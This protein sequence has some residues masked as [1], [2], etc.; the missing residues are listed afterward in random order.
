MRRKLRIAIL[1]T[2]G[3]PNNFGGFEQCAEKIGVRAAS[4]GHEITV[5]NPSDHLYSS[6]KWNG[7]TLKKIF[8]N[9]RRL[10][11]LG[12]FLFDYLSLKDAIKRDFDIILELGYSPS[13]LF[14]YLKK[15]TRAKI[16]TNMAGMEWQRSK[17]N[18]VA[19][20][21]IQFSERIAIRLSDA[22]VSDNPGLQD[23]FLKAYRMETFYIPYGAEL[24]HDPGVQYLPRF[25]VVPYRYFMMVARFQP[26]NN[27]EMILDGYVRS[28]SELPFLVVGNHTNRY[29]KFLRKRYDTIRGI[30]F[31]GAL[32]E[33]ASLSALRWN[34]AMYF[35][36]HSCGGT[37]PSLLEAM[38]S[39]AYIAAHDNP[40]NRYVLGDEGFYF[41]DDKDIARLMTSYPSD[42]RQSFIDRNRD[43]IAHT[44]NWN[45]VTESYLDLF[46]RLASS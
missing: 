35:H 23:Y 19:R 5:Y 13:A 17:W 20:S 22:V 15:Q 27:F 43:K 16:V 28:R 25:E 31:T 10:K 38:A 8:S 12:V 46:S 40:F 14:Y 34:A 18:A 30:R 7:V 32:Y 24:L 42:L 21:I 39:N 26:D 29:G 6:N 3:I 36:G 37:N 4:L 9:E 2:R 11:I 44:Y 33:Y 1:G 41:R 45:A